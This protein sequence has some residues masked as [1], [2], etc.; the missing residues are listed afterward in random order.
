MTRVPGLSSVDA[1][2]PGGALRLVR[3]LAVAQ[4]PFARCGGIRPRGSIRA[5]DGSVLVGA[6]RRW[7]EGTYVRCGL[8]GDRKRILS[9]DQAY[10]CEAQQPPYVSH[11][12]DGG[13]DQALGA[14]VR[15]RVY[16]AMTGY[17]RLERRHSAK[18]SPLR[19]HDV[20]AREVIG[21]QVLRNRL[22]ARKAT[23][24]HSAYRHE[25]RR[26][27][28]CLE[29]GNCCHSDRYTCFRGRHCLIRRRQQERDFSP[30][31]GAA[32]GGVIYSAPQNPQTYVA[33][34]SDALK[35][36]DGFGLGETD[37]A[38]IPGALRW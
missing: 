1:A 34:L 3:R 35:C 17:G 15:I 31:K 20:R 36:G 26:W 23:Y 30:E 6:A 8:P 2:R 29:G 16:N 5:G 38:R 4:L 37:G 14:K 28:P 9:C 33:E 25:R 32:G 12:R 10:L 7:K 11:L 21:D 22:I 13:H 19:E 24:K 27:S 18:T